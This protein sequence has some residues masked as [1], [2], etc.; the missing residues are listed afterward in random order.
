MSTKAAAFLKMAAF[1]S[2]ERNAL[3]LEVVKRCAFLVE[4]ISIRNSV[5]HS[6]DIYW[7]RLK[8]LQ[9]FKELKRCS[10]G[11]PRQVVFLLIQPQDKSFTR[12]LK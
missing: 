10:D 7:V 11:F 3:V 9:I 5:A 12:M 8:I 1:R 2:L 4:F 6:R